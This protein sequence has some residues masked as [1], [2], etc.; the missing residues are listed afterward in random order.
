MSK[1]LFY[2]FTLLPFYL[3]T[4]CTNDSYEA[5]DGDYSYLRADFVELKTKAAKLVAEATNDDNERLAFSN[6]LTVSWAEKGDTIYRALLYYNKVENGLPE[7]FSAVQVPVLKPST[8]KDDETLHTDPLTLESSWTS[9]NGKY[10]NL[11]LLLKTGVEEGLDARQ[12]I[13]VVINDVTEQ[14]DGSK[15]Y[16]LVFYHHQNG[17][18]E[19]YTS[20]VYSSIPTSFFKQGDTATLTIHTYQG[21]VVKEYSF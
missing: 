10:L 5:G 3:F 2:L 17:V 7:P 16:D 1:S 12:S 20:R 9:A 6:P 21:A 18:P 14:S 15:H 8:L 13:G 11:S 19:Y 4:S